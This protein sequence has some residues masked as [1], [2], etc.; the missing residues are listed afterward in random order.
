MNGLLKKT[1]SLRVLAALVLVAFA[2]VGAIG[3]GGDDKESPDAAVEAALEKAA[4]I[5]S[6]KSEIKAS[7]LTGALPASFDIVGGGPF[8]TEA[9][10]GVA[11]DL[12]L[13]VQVA[14]TE[15]AFGV[16]AADGKSYIEVDGKAAELEGDG[17]AAL[18][19]GT[20]NDFI[21]SLSDY[22]LDASFAEKRNLGKE[23]L[24]VYN[25]N[26]D[27]KKLLSDAS[28]DSEAI[29]NFSVPGLGS[30]EE[31]SAG[32]DKGTG[33]VGV[34]SDG[35][36]RTLSVNVPIERGTSLAGVRLSLT[37]NDI[38]QPVT[39]EAPEEIVPRS[40]LG[41]IADLLGG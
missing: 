32:I 20:V 41:G 29:A 19:G 33:S 21:D 15:Q 28:K 25:F 1:A 17:G 3:C 18:D 8:D 10:G 4:D 22:I 6:G 36:P 38:N 12:D 39:I 34:A 2:T 30:A 37:I 40:E 5:K 16:V 35:F 31:L 26:F 27:A 24:Q 23:E 7:I 9:K 14:G 13:A 11:Y